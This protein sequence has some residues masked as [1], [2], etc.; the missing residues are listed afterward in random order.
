MLSMC[1]LN[2]V[3]VVLRN[4]VRMIS[5]SRKGFDKGS[6]LVDW[7]FELSSFYYF[8]ITA[9]S[10]IFFPLHWWRF[11]NC[12]SQEQCFFLEDFVGF[13]CNFDTIKWSFTNSNDTVCFI[14][15]TDVYNLTIVPFFRNNM[16]FFSIT[17]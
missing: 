1:I 4:A 2:H 17:V 11:S 13:L 10:Y 3:Y 7:V 15:C 16:C 14:S 6:S 8:H 5:S 9:S 12:I